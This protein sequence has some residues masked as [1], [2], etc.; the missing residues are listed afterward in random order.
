MRFAALEAP[1]VG[2]AAGSED[3]MKWLGVTQGEDAAQSV[4][5]LAGERPTWLVVD[6]YGLGAEWERALRPQTGNLMVIDDLANRTH[7][8]DLLLDQNFSRQMA[9]RYSGL[10]PADCRLLLGPRYALLGPEYARKRRAERRRDTAIERVFVFFGGS[11]PYNLTGAA[12]EALSRPGLRHLIADIVVGVNNAHASQ[13]RRRA[14]DRPG[15]TVHDPR[16]HL[17]D[18]MSGADLAIGAAGTTTWERMCLG[19]PSLVVSA[20]ENQRPG[21]EALAEEG[22]IQYLGAAREV[23]ISEIAQTIEGIVAGKQDLA[24]Q[25]LLGRLTVDGLGALRVAEC[26]DPTGRRQLQL[27][28]ARAEDVESYFSWVNE[29]Q[30]RRHS[31]NSAAIP[32]L[33]HEQWFSSRLADSRTRMFVLEAKSL[34]VGQV[35]FDTEGGEARI[36]YSIDAPFRGRGWGTSLIAMGMRRLAERGRIVFRADVKAS[37]PASTAVF[38]RLGFQESASSER[39]GFAVFRFD[40]GLRTLPE[41]D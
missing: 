4:E 16:P 22:L 36:D 19:L 31:L 8:C 30:V 2:A 25:S 32:W 38:V 26:I 37:N 28:E 1:P 3:Y 9:A 5:A 20:A 29:A 13:L 15:T 41:I 17:A 10:V 18:L 33:T 14:A 40:S 7:E 24:D 34:P 12:L 35:R 6:H 23:G 39:T 11:D 27:R 21:A